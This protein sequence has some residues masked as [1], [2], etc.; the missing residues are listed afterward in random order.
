MNPE[1]ESNRVCL[2][3]CPCADGLIA[4][5]VMYHHF[6]GDV[7]CIPVAYKQA[8]GRL[9]DRIVEAIC[10]KDVYLVDFTFT[11]QDLVPYIKTV[12]SLTIIDHHTAADDVW[13]SLA[14]GIMPKKD[15]D[16]PYTAYEIDQWCLLV[17]EFNHARENVPVNL[18]F[19]NDYSG[20]SLT[21]AYLNGQLFNHMRY[22]DGVGKPGMPLLVAYAESYDR[23]TKHL[24]K[25]DAFQLGF[26]TMYPLYTTKPALIAQNFA[27][28]TSSDFDLVFSLID[29]G[30]TIQSYEANLTEGIIRRTTAFNKIFEY[31][32]IP[33]CH[34]P[35][36]LANSLGEK[37][38]NKYPEAPFVVVYEDYHDSKTRKLCFRSRKDGGI[39]VAE[40]ARKLGG[41]GHFNSAGVK[42][43]IED[44]P[45]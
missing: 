16:K 38:Y 9:P 44:S 7:E 1:K 32:N 11:P 43:S 5:A 37:L 3:H 23:Y 6:N 26:T 35:M 28:N 20:A 25:T 17:E 39:N 21:W 40:L 8:D 29:D 31:E 30:E 2:Y 19:R 42:I 45:F 10:G 18:V 27:F 33:M 24:P 12:K 4:A 15:E 13:V 41:N 36:E 34:G 22:E 14:A